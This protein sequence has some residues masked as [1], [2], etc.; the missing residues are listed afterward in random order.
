MC[1]KEEMTE[2]QTKTRFEDVFSNRLE[3]SGKQWSDNE[4]EGQRRKYMAEPR[5]EFT[6][7]TREKEGNIYRGSDRT[8]K[9]C[10]ML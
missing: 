3:K 2:S 5:F 1:Y 7:R 9:Y 6:E 8:I 4:G 10:K